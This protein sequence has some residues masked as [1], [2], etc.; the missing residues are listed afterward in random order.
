MIGP[1]SIDVTFRVEVDVLRRFSSL[2][3][4]LNRFSRATAGFREHSMRV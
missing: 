3:A 4:Y 1:D 2:S